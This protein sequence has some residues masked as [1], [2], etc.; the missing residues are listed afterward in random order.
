MDEWESS[1]SKSGDHK[2]DW[3]I[4]GRFVQ[5]EISHSSIFQIPTSACLVRQP[6]ILSDKTVT[7]PSAVVSR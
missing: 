7:I 1:K 5:V 6:Q 4:Y 2:M 3:A